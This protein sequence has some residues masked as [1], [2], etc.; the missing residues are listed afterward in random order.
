MSST[1]FKTIGQNEVDEIIPRL[2]LGD[3]NAALD[4]D[5]LLKNNIN[6]IVNC[7]QTVPVIHDTLNKKDLSLDDIKQLCKIDTFRI[8]VNDSLL[9]KDFILMEQYFKIILPLL[10]RKYTIEKKNILI[11]CFAGKQ[12][13][14]IVVAAFLKILNDNKYIHLTDI[15]KNNI[16]KSVQ[17]QTICNFML[18]KRIQVFTYG[19]KINFIKTY[20]R[21]FN[22][23]L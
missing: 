19:Y 11:H 23:S 17:F 9:E 6:Y 4:T 10:L 16:E 21:Y 18:S 1:I 12:R 14:A 13:S 8:P 7:T 5:F 22:I 20:K 3:A 2:W 15:P